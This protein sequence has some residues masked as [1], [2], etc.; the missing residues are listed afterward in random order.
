M[1]EGVAGLLRTEGGLPVPHVAAW[2]NESTDRLERDPYLTRLG[3]YVPAAFSG[4][5]QGDGHAVLGEMEP[6]RQRRAVID[7]RCQ[8]C[9]RELGERH[10]PNPPWRQPLWLADIR[11][12]GTDDEGSVGADIGGQTIIVGRRRCPLVLEPWVCEP[13]LAYALQVCPGLIKRQT[14]G[15]RMRPALRMLRVR[16]AQVVVVRG[17]IGGDGPVAGRLAA[18]YAKLAVVDFDIV[19]PEQF[20]ASEREAA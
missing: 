20:L 18:T 17:R 14:G 16:R 13:C 9:D 11:V 19:R 12:F 3:Y 7:R 10:R 1:P 8:V 6:A 2:S 5:A 15:T 4:G